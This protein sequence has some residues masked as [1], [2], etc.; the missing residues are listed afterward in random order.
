MR[1]VLDT[2]VVVA[3]LLWAGAPRGLIDAAIDD[4]AILL[5]S[6][7]ALIEELANTLA[8]AK[9]TQ[10]I[11]RFGT[12]IAALVAQYEAMVN[13]ISPAEVSR[14]VLRDPD[15]DHVVACAVAAG[16]KVIVSGDRHL[17]DIKSYQE[18]AILSP[19]EVLRIIEMA[20][21]SG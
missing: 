17:L 14:V 18:I 20:K 3:G 12:S 9:F 19:V 13:V 7:P 8:Y 1:L 10:R 2:N 15:D 5:F 11:A 21:R 6:S 16:A 4:E